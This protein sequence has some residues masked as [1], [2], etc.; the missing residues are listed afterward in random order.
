M[1][2]RSSRARL[3]A[4][5]GVRRWRSEAFKCA[6]REKIGYRVGRPDPSALA[7]KTSEVL[8]RSRATTATR[9][10]AA[11]YA[12]GEQAQHK[13]PY[14]ATRGPTERFN[15]PV[16]AQRAA[17][18]QAE[19]AFEAAKAQGNEAAMKRADAT[20]AEH[21]GILK[22]LMDF[23]SGLARFGS[24]YA[25]VAQ[26]KDM[27]DPDLESFA[28][29]ARLLSKRPDGVPPEHVDVS[30]LVLTGFDIKA[31]ERPDPREPVDEGK[32]ILQPIGP[33]GGGQAPLP[34][35]LRDIIARLNAST[36][37][38]TP[39]TDRVAFVDQLADITREDPHTMAQVANNPREVALRG[40][41]EGTVQAAV[42]R[43]MQSH[44]GLAEHV[45]RQDRQALEPLVGLIHELIKSGRN[46]GLSSEG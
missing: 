34:V 43:A 21:A 35:Y 29:F 42:V 17:I 22:Q 33:G 41:I 4:P 16:K 18:A 13:E 12:A 31:K 1:R 40:N 39:L 28:S 2:V 38:T 37:E 23:K 14:A 45:L 8:V 20:R 32:L 9:R 44:Q 25:Y 3:G 15:E 46:I 19:A 6:V 30:A 26:I 10:S 5:R 11:A 36:G 7:D 27:G 24:L